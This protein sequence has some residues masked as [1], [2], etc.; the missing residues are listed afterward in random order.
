MGDQWGSTNNSFKAFQSGDQL[1][2]QPMLNQNVV[3]TVCNLEG[4]SS[5]APGVQGNF[6]P[7]SSPTINA[8]PSSTDTSRKSAKSRTVGTSD[9]YRKQR[10]DKSIQLRKEKRQDRTNIERRKVRFLILYPANLTLFFFPN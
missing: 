4:G 6:P 3:S 2:F 8:N 9:V 1:L 7:S 5:T 10:E